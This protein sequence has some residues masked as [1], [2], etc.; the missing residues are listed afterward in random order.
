PT[1]GDGL[2]SDQTRN[3]ILA[4]P[5]PHSGK[6][7]AFRTLIGFLDP[8]FRDLPDDLS[9]ERRTEERRRLARQ[10]VQRRRADIEH[11]LGDTPFP[12]REV[13]EETYE[14]TDEYRR[15]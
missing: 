11:Y 14:L 15:L 2:A 4:T 12:A 1:R 3:M 7:E 8:S 13:R 5:T 6:E 10:F 9:A